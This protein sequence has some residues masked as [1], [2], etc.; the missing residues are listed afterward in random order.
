MKKIEKGSLWSLIDDWFEEGVKRGDF[1]RGF[2][3]DVSFDLFTSNSNVTRAEFMKRLE[4]AL[5]KR[6]KELLELF[7]EEWEYSVDDC[8]ERNRHEG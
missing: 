2:V 4:R 3:G 5:A 8:R 7:D 1:Y 6:T